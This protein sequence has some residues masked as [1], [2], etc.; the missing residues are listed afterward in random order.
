MR[1]MRT[2][3]HISVII[4]VVFA[5]YY[6]A[7]HNG[8]VYD[9]A[10]QV[11]QN[12]WITG[13]GHI[14]DI[15]LKNSIGF[16]DIQSNYYRPMMHLF[17]M[18]SY[19]IFGLDAWGF[20]LVNITLH[21]GVTILV[22][23][24]ASRL[25]EGNGAASRDRFRLLPLS[26]A[27]LFAA[28]PIHTE[29][30]TWVAGIPD[31][32]FSFF[33]LLSVYLYSLSDKGRVLTDKY[34]LASVAAFFIA[35]F[36]KEPA[37]T[38]LG[39]FLACD[40]AFGA[41]SFSFLRSLK[42]LAPFL[43][44]AFVYLA[45]RFN[46][47]QGIAPYNWHSGLGPYQVAINIPPL[48]VRYLEKLLLPIDLNFFQTFIPIGSISSPE[49]ML[50]VFIVLIYLLSGFIAMKKDRLLFLGMCIIVFPLLPAL[51]IP[52][53]GENVFA[54]RYLYLPSVGFIIIVVAFLARARLDKARNVVAAALPV[55]VVTGLYSMGTVSRNRVF[56]DEISLWSDTVKKSPDAA[57][58][59]N[60]L[61]TAYDIDGRPEE[62]V[63]AFREAIK[64]SPYK[65]A[66]HYNLGIAYSRCGRTEEAI[67]AFREAVKLSPD[68]PVF[69]NYLGYALK[70][71]GRYDAAAGEFSVAARLDST[72]AA[73]QKKVVDGMMRQ[74]TR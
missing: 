7:L 46:A 67:T 69:H 52:A 28:H 73:I 45:F 15:F 20:H 72:N 63:M 57:Q 2:W 33:G 65:A 44:I 25:L 21:A 71:A 43:A 24:L 47:V 31:V 3:I 1:V 12:P 50:S 64:L 4:A 22:Y 26:A 27:L 48:F 39:I 10:F 59:Y 56:R 58:P 14:P 74:G 53:L 34:Y 55:I 40:Y 62:A 13:L 42:R 60:S 54:E 17:Y 16:V 68:N 30:V 8:F 32:S 66:F 49:A 5:V 51:Y 61:G 41:G 29:A 37:L 6:N 18:F 11:L 23:L 19:G 38:F 70:A 9:D 36:C 35:L